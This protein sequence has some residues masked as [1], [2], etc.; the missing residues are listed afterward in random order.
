MDFNKEYK[1][2]NLTKVSDYIWEIGKDFKSGMR[3]PARLYASEG[4]LNN[5]D[6][7]VYD[8][9]TN[10]ATLPGIVNYAYCMP[11]GHSG[12]GFPIGGVAAM[13]IANGGVISPGGI[14]FDINC[15]HPDTKMLSNYGYFKK[16]KDL[17][18]TF[19]GE[20]LSKLDLSTKSKSSSSPALF[21]R[22]KADTLTLKITTRFGEE[23]ILSE[24]HPI[25][26]ENGFKEAGKLKAGD[27][28]LIH[29]FVGAEYEDPGE[30]II[31]S[32]QDIEALVGKR[33]KL[34][35]ELKSHGLLPLKANNPK[36]P[37]LAKLVGFMTGDG[38][39]GHYYSKSRK[40]N[41]WSARAIGKPDD[42]ELIRQ[43][44][45]ALGYLANFIK[46]QKYDSEVQHYDNTRSQISGSSTQLYLLSQS[47]TVLL[48]ALGVP[49]GNKSRK[50]VDVPLWVKSS[51]LWIKRL[52]LAGLFGAELTKPAQRNGEPR[53]FIE[54]SFSQN[55][56]AALEKDNLNFMLD[57]INLLL[58]FGIHTNNIYRQVGVINVH[59]ERTSK[60]AIRISSKPE[61]L[62]N[63]WSKIGFE[64]C[65]ERS[66]LSLQAV[67]YLKYKNSEIIR[68]KSILEIKQG[69][70]IVRQIR[71]TSDFPS[72]ADFKEKQKTSPP[73][74]IS[75]EV[76]SISIVDYFGDVY[77]LTMAD[78]DHNFIANSIVSHNCGMRLIRTDLT[79]K[80]VQPKLH[81][82]VNRLFEKVPSGVGSKGFVKMDANTFRKMTEEGAAWC[83]DKGYGWADDLEATEL[84]GCDKDADATKVSDK[85]VDRGKGQ[86][87]TLGSGNH[88]L[89][90]QHVKPDNIIDKK[91]AKK[92]GIFE[93][94]IVIMF[95]C[96]SR[97]F[98][99]QVAT[100][101][102]NTFLSVMES[103]YNIKIL[104][105]ELACAPFESPEGKDYFSAMKCAMNM[106]FANRQT[107]AH[108]IREV[109]AEVFATDA[110]KLG[111]RQIYDVSH[112][113]ASLEKH[114]VGGSMK[115]LI[116][117]RKGAT[118]AYGPGR[119]ELGTRY[120]EDGQPVIIG[121][122]METGSYLLVGCESGAQTWFTTAHGSGR[123]MS[124]AK[125]KQLYRG[126]QLQKDMEA[127]GIYVK[128]ASYAGLAEEAGG[129][130]KDIDG[131]IDTTDK[132][133]I[134][135]KVV[136][137]VPIGNV[138][139]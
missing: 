98:G 82:L 132:S 81:Q 66:A 136:K 54:P 125:A 56:I 12:Y 69:S 22:K 106:S 101:Y 61:N 32:E 15:L 67:S 14:G 11:D 93:D 2:P 121:G 123:T 1:K 30:K 77:D 114:K 113:R 79:F 34:I 109:F 90:I 87:G 41:V 29:P 21:L 89:E 43:D 80:D 4:L 124:R 64:Y 100:D 115:E 35:N 19:P 17:E 139:G 50:K 135:K 83:V 33:K 137:L 127:R 117:H 68:R 111:M 13:D 92:W 44:I 131:V 45:F 107:I 31:V 57:I 91:L 5:I 28:I 86:I 97:G 6:L 112:N 96:G 99:H 37:I 23:I 102:L 48:H 84:G 46:T 38:W 3:V 65:L 53:S 71:I 20:S 16:I 134:S 88:Y 40:M 94:Q 49:E 63:L 73:Q 95:H 85:A 110:E 120:K 27:S 129:A 62:I 59:G 60:L 58:D 26:S 122:S 78:A 18:M 51:P 103:K 36:V 70:T 133:G 7:M 8:Q 116:V 74:F 52:Y 25:Y 130:Y 75:D 128:T 42:L 55:K 104:D 108:R 118:A 119:P 126:D 9:I 47:L 72:F 138:K 10:V 39:L 24:D 76:D 105:R